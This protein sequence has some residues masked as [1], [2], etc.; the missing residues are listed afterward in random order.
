MSLIASEDS[1]LRDVRSLAG[2]SCESS[3]SPVGM[4]AEPPP[5]PLLGKEGGLVSTPLM[6]DGRFALFF[7]SGPPLL[8]GEGW[9]EVNEPLPLLFHKPLRH[10]RFLQGGRLHVPPSPH[11][12]P[13]LE[14]EDVSARRKST[15]S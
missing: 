4:C 1:Q 2:E 13:L 12:D 10:M 14:G 15:V 5:N 6:G 8:R 7:R 9:G 3:H 11:L